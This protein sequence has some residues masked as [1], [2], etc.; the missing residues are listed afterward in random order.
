[1]L[2]SPEPCKFIFDA[3]CPKCKFLSLQKVVMKEA[4]ETKPEQF[5]YWCMNCE[6][7]IAD[8]AEMPL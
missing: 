2:F 3:M 7:Y 4:T 1:M 6:D 8:G 5:K